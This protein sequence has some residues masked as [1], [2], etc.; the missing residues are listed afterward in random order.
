MKYCKTVFGYRADPVNG[1]ELIWLIRNEVALYHAVHPEGE[2]IK[3]EAS[4]L[5]NMFL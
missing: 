1:E 4:G 3:K 5:L 2:E